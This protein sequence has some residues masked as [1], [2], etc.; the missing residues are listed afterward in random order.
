MR[1]LALSRR[2]FLYGSATSLLSLYTLPTLGKGSRSKG[3]LVAPVSESLY[4]Q[5]G[6]VI[7]QTSQ[8]FVFST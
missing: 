6:E 4:T 2:H 5:F 1:K 7:P 3:Y 8:N